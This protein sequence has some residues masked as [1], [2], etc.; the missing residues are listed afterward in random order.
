[1]IDAVTVTMHNP[2]QLYARRAPAS[3]LPSFLR[4]Y[5]FSLATGAE[6][7]GTM[8][9]LLEVMRTTPPHAEEPSSG[10]RVPQW[11][12]SVQA[13]VTRGLRKVAD[14]VRRAGRREMR[15]CAGKRVGTRSATRVRRSERS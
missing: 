11:S 2:G 15:L 8:A 13:D 4:R 10:H 14:R 3:W 12:P 9:V 5:R 7:A 1:M 6:P